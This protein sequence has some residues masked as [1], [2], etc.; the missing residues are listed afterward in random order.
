MPDYFYAIKSLAIN[1]RELPTGDHESELNLG[2]QFISSFKNLN[3]L[4]ILREP[5]DNV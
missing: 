1:A 5:L 2:C 4:R 3:E